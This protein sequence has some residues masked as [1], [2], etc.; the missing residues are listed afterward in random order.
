MLKITPNTKFKDALKNP[1]AK[2]MLEKLM[3]AL[4]L[5]SALITNGPLGN[6]KFKLLNTL[7]AGLIDKNTVQQICDMLNLEKDEVI[8][9]KGTLEK[10]VEGSG[11]LSGLSPLVL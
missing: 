7:T 10:M 3:M 6:G 1:M 8:T 11:Y 4:R 2:D 5:P 9:D